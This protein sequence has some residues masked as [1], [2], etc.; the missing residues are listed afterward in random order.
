MEILQLSKYEERSYRETPS[1][2]GYINYGD[3]NLFP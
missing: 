3:D 1:N 2:Q